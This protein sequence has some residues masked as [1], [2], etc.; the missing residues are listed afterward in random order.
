M[1]TVAITAAGR[2]LG[3]ELVRHYAAGGDRVLAFC[4]DPASRDELQRI[5]RDSGGRITTH[6][7]YVAS[8]ASVATAV[9]EIN[10]TPIDVLLNVAAIVGN[11]MPELESGSSDW[12]GWQEVF[13]TVTMGPL[14]VIQAFLPRLRAGDKVMNVSSQV[15]TSMWLYGGVYAYGAAKAA[16]NRLTLS[17][18]LDLAPRGITV[19]LIHPGWMNTDMG[20]P[21]AETKVEESAAGIRRIVA[22]WPADG[23]CHFRKWTGE[24]QIW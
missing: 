13:N 3:L 24:P 4:R 8:D 15:G 23:Q 20:G 9:A 10:D 16:L 18:A 7:M 5:A 17:L 19:G 2:G 6:T 22:D 1:T 14:R 12:G 21:D 11:G